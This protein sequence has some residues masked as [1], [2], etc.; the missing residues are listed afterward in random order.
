M[1][2]TSKLSDKIRD[3]GTRLKKNLNSFD[4]NE[5]IGETTPSY[6][7]KRSRGHLS[8]SEK[9]DI[10]RQVK[11]KFVPQREVAKEFRVSVATVSALTMKAHKDPKY[12]R[13]L[14]HQN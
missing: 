13:E 3:R 5:F 1:H 4:S 9:I 12:L 6:R 2:D 10:V 11:F 14:A 7:K 8:L